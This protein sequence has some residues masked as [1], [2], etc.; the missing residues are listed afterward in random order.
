[1][2]ELKYK[3]TQRECKCR[4]C[5]KMILRG[6]QALV[7]ERVHVSP[8]WKDL[9]FHTDCFDSAY[10]NLVNRCTCDKCTGLDVERHYRLD[11]E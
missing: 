10:T 1:V 2:S 11:E 8:N 7:M 5:N 6:A 3:T 9:Y 4:L